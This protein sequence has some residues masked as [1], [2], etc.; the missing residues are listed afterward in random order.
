MINENV[1]INE[2]YN[3]KHRNDD[4]LHTHYD[5]E[6]N[7][8]KKMIPHYVYGNDTMYQ[9]INYLKGQWVWMIESVLPIKNFYNY[10]VGK[11]WNKHNY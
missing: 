3:L 10:T 4:E 9:F 1:Q 2:I 5:Y 11:Y 6:N 7:L 8:I